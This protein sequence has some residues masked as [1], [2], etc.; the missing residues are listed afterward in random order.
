ML[1]FNLVIPKR[2]GNC[3]GEDHHIVEEEVKKEPNENP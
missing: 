2:A 1:S 3:N